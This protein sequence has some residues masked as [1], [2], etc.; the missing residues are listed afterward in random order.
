MRLP[1]WL[2]GMFDYRLMASAS[3]PTLD[4]HL[5]QLVD[6]YEIDLVLDV[7]ANTGQFGA[8]LR[9]A[10]YRG[11]IHSFEPVRE[12]FERLRQRSERDRR[13]HVHRI[14]MGRT[15]GE[16]VINVSCGTNM[17]SFLDANDLG[18]RLFDEIA[19]S[20]TER[21][22]VDTLHDFLSSHADQTMGRRILLK[23]DTQGSD[24]EV[25]QGAGDSLSRIDVVVSELS[26]IP[27]YSGMPDYLDVLRI[28]KEC[29]FLVTGFFPVNRAED[30]SV[31][32]VD[33]AFVSAR[34]A[35]HAGVPAAVLNQVDGR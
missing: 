10:G 32:E 26:V 15:R 8:L 11:A 30:F 21:V 16:R 4:A 24:L 35:W 20:A 29:G 28:Y 14:A 23:T 33:C 12:A 1:R 22:S 9:E 34:H 17:S 25:V 13:W 3:H 6:R 2:R 19:V 5:M 18:R 7:G 31:I 27:I